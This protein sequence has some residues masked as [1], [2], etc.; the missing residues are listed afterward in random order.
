MIIKIVD[1][2]HKRALVN[3]KWINHRKYDYETLKSM[4]SKTPRWSI[5]GYV[6]PNCR[7]AGN[8]DIF[9]ETANDKYFCTFCR[10]QIAS[11][12]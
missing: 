4:K 3:G 9:M 1:A 7:T 6:C 2:K 11:C 12:K 5:M 8:Q 10:V